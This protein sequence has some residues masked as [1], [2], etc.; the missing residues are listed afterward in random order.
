VQDDGG[1]ANGGVNLDPTPNTITVNVT[2][3]NDAPVLAEI[4]GS[5]LCYSENAPA[6]AITVALIA[7]DVDNTTMT[8]AT[9]QITGNYQKC[10]DVLSFADTASITGTWDAVTG[11]LTLSSS[12]TLANYQLAL[13]SVK[14]ENSSENPSTLT[15]TMT[16]TVSDGMADSN[17]VTRDIAI[18]AV[19]DPPTVTGLGL[20]YSQISSGVVFSTATGNAIVVSDVDAGNCPVQVTLWASNSVVTLAQTQGL[21]FAMREG[22]ADGALVFTGNLADVNAALD[23]LRVRAMAASTRLEITVNDQGSS[24]A[25]GPRTVGGLFSISQSAEP[26]LLNSTPDPTPTSP[27]ATPTHASTPIVGMPVPSAPRPAPT[28]ATLDSMLPAVRVVSAGPKYAFA[29]TRK[30]ESRIQDQTDAQ[31]IVVT[32]A[33]S[34]RSPNSRVTP[35]EQLSYVAE[36]SLLWNDLDSLKEQ[37]QSATHVQDLVVGSAVT[38]TTGLTAGYVLWMIRGGLLISSIIAQ[39]PAWRLVDP[40]VILSHL[41]EDLLERR[42]DEEAETIESIVSSLDNTPDS[43]GELQR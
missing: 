9:I 8:G 22:Q 15:R 40:L 37:M 32:A 20:Q 1:T 4:E 5:T 26:P 11:T 24:G 36:G 6:T 18:N 21:T 35:R 3:V 39:M 31:A 27:E 28:P 43:V 14:Y 2:A 17:A 30:A 25:G 41:D 38:V 29:I 19:N 12:D 7:C 16:F 33:A 23:G 42:D 34:P 13:Q 10:E